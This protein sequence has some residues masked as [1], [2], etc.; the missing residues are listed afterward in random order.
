MPRVATGS[1]DT[2]HY[3]DDEV[4]SLVASAYLESTCFILGG[5]HEGKTDAP[6]VPPDVT[7]KLCT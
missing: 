7:R 1:V 3:S 2:P 4:K 5:A 6:I